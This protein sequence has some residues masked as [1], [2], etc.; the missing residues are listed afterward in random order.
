MPRGA[1]CLVR[2][3]GAWGTLALALLLSVPAGAQGLASISITPA[4]AGP[5]DT[6]QGR[7]TLTGPAPADR[8]Y[9]QISSTGNVWIPGTVVV[10][11]G[12]TTATFVVS[13]N[14]AAQES[15][16][17][18]TGSYNGQ[19]VTSNPL[20]CLPDPKVQAQAAQQAAQAAQQ[21]APA[22]IYNYGYGN[23]YWYPGYPYPYP[24]TTPVMPPGG[25]TFV[26]STPAVG[27][28]Q[29]M[30]GAPSGPV[31]DFGDN[32]PRAGGGGRR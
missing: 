3:F 29:G 10:P 6:V 9:V 30:G 27:S 23:Y 32:V 17:Q 21:A 12:Q 19:R 16:A 8:A 4:S 2:A 1:S 20:T 18:V 25:Q 26:N 11:P 31:M 13:V 14:P 22:P 15:T 7:V 24:G 5:N 28:F